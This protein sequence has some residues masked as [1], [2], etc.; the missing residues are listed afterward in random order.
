MCF[1][2]TAIFVNLN[3]LVKA[4][5]SRFVYIWRS[6]KTDYMHYNALQYV[7]M[8]LHKPTRVLTT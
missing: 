7:S 5:T 8:C 2:C 1:D 4:A 3:K 6:V